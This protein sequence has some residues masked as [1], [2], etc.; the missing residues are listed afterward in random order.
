MSATWIG[1]LVEDGRDPVKVRVTGT[2]AD[3]RLLVVSDKV[4]E[5]APV[6]PGNV[7][8]KESAAWMARMTQHQRAAKAEQ[9][10][11]ERCRRQAMAADAREIRASL[12]GGDA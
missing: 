7:H 11:A 2:T 9:E 1:W 12:T 8:D 4:K 6:S 5:A 3:G 10:R